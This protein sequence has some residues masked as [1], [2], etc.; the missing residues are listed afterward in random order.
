[1]TKAILIAAI[2]ILTAFCFF[3]NDGRPRD[4]EGFEQRTKERR[5]VRPGPSPFTE[6]SGQD[7]EQANSDNAEDDQERIVFIAEDFSD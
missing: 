2:E 6:E 7:K 1:M 5:K 4:N 3:D